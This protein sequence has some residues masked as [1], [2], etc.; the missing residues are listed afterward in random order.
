[1]KVRETITVPQSGLGSSGKDVTKVRVRELAKGEK[2]PADAVRVHE[3]TKV[4]DWKE[5]K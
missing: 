5:V 3:S 2:M 4:H 1:M